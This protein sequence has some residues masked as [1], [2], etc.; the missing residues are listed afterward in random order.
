MNRWELPNNDRAPLHLLTLATCTLPTVSTSRSPRHTN[1]GHRA[2]RVVCKESHK[3]CPQIVLFVSKRIL[4][5]CK[6]CARRGA[7]RGRHATSYGIQAKKKQ[8]SHFSSFAFFVLKSSPFQTHPFF[9]L[10]TLAIFTMSFV[11][12]Y[13]LA[14]FK[15]LLQSC[16]RMLPLRVTDSSVFLPNG[17]EVSCTFQNTASNRPPES[18]PL[19]GMIIANSR[20]HTF[21]FILGLC[22]SVNGNL[23]DVSMVMPMTLSYISWMTPSLS[24]SLFKLLGSENHH[25][26]HCTTHGTSVVGAYM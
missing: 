21:M 15:R 11:H 12:P 14:N 5:T 3:Q 20:L 13:S 9:S 25:S 16:S 26:T 7:N 23:K 10:Q 6:S 17:S 1:L 8:R 19:R 24:K 2:A 18:L 4:F 22:I